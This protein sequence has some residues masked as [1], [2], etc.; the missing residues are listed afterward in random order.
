MH[1]PCAAD[2]M[3]LRVQ[4]EAEAVERRVLLSG[5]LLTASTLVAAW[6]ARAVYEKQ[7]KQL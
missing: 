1:K 4:W 6:A 2:G 5:C 3:L 7:M